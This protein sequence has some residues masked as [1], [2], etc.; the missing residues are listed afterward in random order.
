[1]IYKPFFR[2]TCRLCFQRMETLQ[3]FA[4]H[5][6]F[7]LG[8]LLQTFTIHRTAREGGGYLFNSSVPLQP[9]SHTHL[10]IR[11]AITAENS[12]LHISSSRTRTGNRAQGANH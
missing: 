2:K 4:M 1:M 8:F 10:D 7:Y 5:F 11:Q 6:F 12:P 9:A 3:P